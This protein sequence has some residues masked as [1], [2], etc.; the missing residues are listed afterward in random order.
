MTG[1]PDPSGRPAFLATVQGKLISGLT[2]I[3]LV[4]GI[5]AEGVS[6]YRN[7]KETHT[8]TEVS[9]NSTLRQEA[10]AK[11]AKAESCSARLKYLAE[12]STL[13]E[14]QHPGKKWDD[15]K[16]ECDPEYAAQ[17]DKC[18]KD[19]D[20]ILADLDKV[21][22]EEEGKPVIERFKKHKLNCIITAEQRQHLAVFQ[23]KNDRVVAENRKKLAALELAK[24]MLL[25]GKEKEAGHFDKSF[26]YSKKAVELSEAWDKQYSD[27]PNEYTSTSLVSLSFHAIF[28][29]QYN[30]A[31]DAA[32]RAIDL[33]P[34]KLEPYTNRAHALMFLGRADEAKTAYLAHRGE[35]MGKHDWNY[36]IADDFKQFRAAGITHPLM[37]DIEREL[38]F[39]P[40][41]LPYQ[42]RR[43]SVRNRKMRL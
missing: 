41:P 43:G 14:L 4:L 42:S 40:T 28:A 19:F 34:A 32:T 24:N 23:E 7:L 6:L 26:E 29:R 21:H 9:I 18:D 2:I 38:G 17:A 15:L 20:A 39:R 25:A 35:K 31:L 22:N 30:T 13:E 33:N 10:E 27:K 12:L 16:R 3:A 1:L 36:Y 37:A 5:A 8:A 11:R